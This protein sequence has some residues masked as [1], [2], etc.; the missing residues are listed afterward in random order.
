MIGNNSTPEFRQRLSAVPVYYLLVAFMLLVMLGGCGPGVGSSTGATGAPAQNQPTTVALS[1]SP[2]PEIDS[3]LTSFFFSYD[4]SGSTASRDLSLFTLA[5]RRLPD[6]SLGRP[7]EFLNAESFDHFDADDAG[8]FKISMG[9]LGAESGVLPLANQPVSTELASGVYALGVNLSGPERSKADRRNVVL[10]L[11]LDV[12]GSMQTSYAA[13]TG[14]DLSSLLD[15]AKFGISKLQTSLKSGDVVNL[16]TFSTEAKVILEN[17]SL[18]SNSL[19]ATLD[20][21]ST[22]AST[23]IDTGVALAY[24]V[25]NRTFDTAKANRVVILTDAYV[26]TGELDPSIIAEHTSINGLEG[27]FFSGIGIG[28]N[29]NDQFLDS[30]TDIGKG[31]YSSMITPVDAE[32]IFTT[33]F[34]RFLEPAVRN[35]RFQLNYPQALDQLQSFAEEISAEPEAVQPVHFSYNSDQ[36]FLELFSGPESVASDEVISLTIDFENTEGESQQQVISRTLGELLVRGANEI[37][38]AAA[39]TTLAQLINRSLDCESVLASG[40]YNDTSIV[41]NVYS[42]YRQHIDTFCSL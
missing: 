31:T 4:E 15:V 11:L 5:D 14:S 23:D 17:Y 39:V 26:N 27:I 18:S 38:S 35:V 8:P 21:I 6:S 37:K 36:F 10:T 30:L 22:E 24:Q 25:A 29:F 7:Y 20:D 3:E 40:L 1:D 9:M 41:N 28:D 16:V 34:Q 13:E 42:A 32:R 12:S 19:D 2:D 33:G